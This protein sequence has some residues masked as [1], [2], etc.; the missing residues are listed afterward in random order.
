MIARPLT[1]FAIARS[2]A[3]ISSLAAWPLVQN[4]LFLFGAIGLSFQEVVIARFDP[5]KPDQNRS[6]WTLGSLIA[7]AL[8]LLYVGAWI[9]GASEIWF[10]AVMAAPP[11]LLPL[12]R[13]AIVV[14][15]PVPAF[16]LVRATLNGILVSRRT[17][18]F[19]TIAT[20]ANVSVQLA[21]A[22]T[23]PSLTALVGTA[24]AGCMLV[25]AN[26]TQAAVLT[27]GVAA[28]RRRRE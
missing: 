12:L 15:L 26:I 10:A 21:L 16:A 2:N 4:Y 22:L 13:I 20:V 14:I 1:A 28:K 11:S 6:I 23:L 25:G 17:T 27:Y 24:V 3:P 18:T 8:L 9:S 7:V 5:K 19:I